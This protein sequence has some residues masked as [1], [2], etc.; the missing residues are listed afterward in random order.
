MDDDTTTADCIHCQHSQEDISHFFVFCPPKQRVWTI[1]TRR[2]DSDWSLDEIFTYIRFMKPPQRQHHPLP[3]LNISITLSTIWR[4]HWRRVFDHQPF[5]AGI[6]ANT[7]QR[8]LSEALWQPEAL[9][10]QDV[11]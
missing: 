9:D 11:D 10:S 2:S 1:V 7:V 8:K 5:K 6:V 4:H 3:D